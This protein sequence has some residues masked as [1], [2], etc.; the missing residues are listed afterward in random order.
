MLTE[1]RYTD[2]VTV[3]IYLVYYVSFEGCTKESM[4]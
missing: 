3:M 2:T 1:T 4:Y